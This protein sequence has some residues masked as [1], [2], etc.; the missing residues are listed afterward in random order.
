MPLFSTGSWEHIPWNL[1]RW[2]RVAEFCSKEGW[3]NDH[4]VDNKNLQQTQKLPDLFIF[5]SFNKYCLAAAAAHQISHIVLSI[6]RTSQQKKKKVDTVLTSW[7]YWSTGHFLL[8]HSLY[9]SKAGSDY[10]EP[11]FQ[12]SH[13][14][15]EETEARNDIS[16]LLDQVC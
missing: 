3:R 8:I 4:W 2:R 1:G 12:P 14:R 16:H 9:G 7:T 13:F 5:H 11:V 15:G 6:R 10:G